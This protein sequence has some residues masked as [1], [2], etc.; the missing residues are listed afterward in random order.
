MKRN[1]NLLILVFTVIGLVVVDV[2]TAA[3]ETLLWRIGESDNNAGE[4]ALG[5]AGWGGLGSKFESDCLFVIG[6][7][8]PKR[9]WAYV[10][11]G[12]A[13]SWAG[14]KKHEYAVVFGIDKTVKEGK[15]KLIIDLLDTHS[16]SRSL[17]HSGKV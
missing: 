1:M 4:F 5:P 6:E 14:S 3:D 2:V 12:P 8:D 7:S 10:L 15:C 11:P 9:D 13:D 16:R 17:S